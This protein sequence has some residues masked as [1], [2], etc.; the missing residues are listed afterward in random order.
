MDSVQK[1]KTLQ[2]EMLIRIDETRVKTEEKYSSMIKNY[3]ET[4]RKAAGLEYVASD[5]RR[6]IK[7]IKTDM[8]AMATTIKPTVK[9]TEKAVI[10]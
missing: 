3:N 8:I 10:I 5:L 6:E 7:K 1:L 9:E 4:K 2:E